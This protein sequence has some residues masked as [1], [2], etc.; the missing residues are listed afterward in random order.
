MVERYAHVAPSGL[1]FAAS[2]LDFV[3]CKRSGSGDGV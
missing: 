3:V 1:E 2:R